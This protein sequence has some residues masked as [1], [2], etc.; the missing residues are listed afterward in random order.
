MYTVHVATIP[1]QFLVSVLYTD[2]ADNIID[3]AQFNILNVSRSCETLKNSIMEPSV[4]NS[5]SRAKH[6]MPCYTVDDFTDMDEIEVFMMLRGLSNKK[7]KPSPG[8]QYR[9]I[10]TDID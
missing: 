10:L 1:Y 6:K 3:P 2:E 4:V 7:P 8:N 9:P 5:V